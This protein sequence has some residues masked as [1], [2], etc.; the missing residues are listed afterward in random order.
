MVVSR[1]TKQ[2]NH[3]DY[4]VE[5]GDLCENC[6]EKETACTFCDQPLHICAQ[7]ED[8]KDRRIPRRFRVIADFPDYMIDRYAAIRHISTGRYCTLVRINPQSNHAMV[9]LMRDGKRHTKSAQ[10]L[11]DAAFAEDINSSTCKTC[12][13][14]KDRH[15]MN[16]N[17]KI[18]LEAGCK[19]QQYN[20]FGKSKID[21]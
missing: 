15:W 6:G 19:C 10:V 14:Q 9:N 20:Q 12:G 2:H 8:P 21:G 3:K 17:T 13:H 4:A 5:T 1:L 7:S 16:S 18:C 11:R